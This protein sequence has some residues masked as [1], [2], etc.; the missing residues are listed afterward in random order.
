M[1]ATCDSAF[2]SLERSLRTGDLPEACNAYRALQ[3]P[4]SAGA[5]AECLRRAGGTLNVL[6][7]NL[8]A[9]GQALQSGDLGE[10]RV[11]YTRLEMDLRRAVSSRAEPEVPALFI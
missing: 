11:A 7:A 8:L 5:S 2:L 10:A 1:P 3:P 9:I 4:V 6:G